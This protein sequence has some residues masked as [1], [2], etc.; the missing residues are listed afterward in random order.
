M[1]DEVV[2]ESMTPGMMVLPSR[3]RTGL[4]HAPLV[5]M[6]WIGALEGDGG[7]AGGQHEVDDVR[8]R[9]VE[10]VRPLV[11]AQ[12]TCMRICSG[13]RWRGQ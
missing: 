5:R 13:G 4:E 3:H 8:Q 12:H 2:V 1:L 9:H 7:G 6:P 10:V 11:V